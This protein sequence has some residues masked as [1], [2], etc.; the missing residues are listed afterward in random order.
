ML[1][2]YEE[3]PEVLKI[4]VPNFRHLLHNLTTYNDEDIK[5]NVQTRI[6]LIH[7]REVFTKDS[8]ELLQS[9]FLSVHHLND[10]KRLILK[11]VKL[12]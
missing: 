9:I 10:L 12:L 2:A 3:L 6:L 1:K 4:Y 5:G 8:N 11:G 7:F